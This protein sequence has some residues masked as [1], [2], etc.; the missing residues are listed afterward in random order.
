MASSKKG[1]AFWHFGGDHASAIAASWTYNWGVQAWQN[2]GGAEF[3]PMIWGRRDNNDDHWHKANAQKSIYLLGPNEPDNHGEEA[4]GLSAHEVAADYWPAMKWT[5]KKLGSPAVAGSDK[6]M[7]EFMQECGDL[8]DFICVHDYPKLTDTK[9]AVAHVLG[10]C[11]LYH[12]KYGNK[13]IWLTEFGSIYNEPADK[14]VAFIEAIVPELEKLDIIQRYAWFSDYAY[15]GSGS[16]ALFDGSGRLT[17]VGQ[18]Y[19][20]AAP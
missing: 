17:R 2:Q 19:R 20:D 13:P 12:E 15:R 16:S 18:A 7:D 14:V 8:V 5:G 4:A 9:A 1:G 3:V 11:Q 6:W 10:K